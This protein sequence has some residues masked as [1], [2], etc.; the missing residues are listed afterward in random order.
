MAAMLRWR[1]LLLVVL[2]IFF[3]LVL[4]QIKRL[5]NLRDVGRK[6]APALPLRSPVLNGCE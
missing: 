6:A 1:S 4:I 5:D 3:M 2:K